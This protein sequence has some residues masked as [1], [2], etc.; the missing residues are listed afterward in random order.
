[1]GWSSAYNRSAGAL[2]WVQILRAAQKVHRGS[3][4]AC[5]TSQ[6]G[7]ALVCRTLVAGR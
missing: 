5:F 7:H 6:G 4:M 2:D 3:G 1:M